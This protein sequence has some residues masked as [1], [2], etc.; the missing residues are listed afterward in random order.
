MEIVPDGSSS[1]YSVLGIC[2]HAS[3]DEIRGAYRKL[4]LKWHPDRCTKDPAIAGEA[5][6]KFQQIQEAYSVLSDKGKRTIYDAGLLEDPP[7]EDDNND[8]EFDKF[9]REMMSLMESERSQ[10]ERSLED[11]QRLLMEMMDRD[12]RLKFELDVKQSHGEA[13]KRRRTSTGG[14]L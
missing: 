3:D 4:A 9:M 6:D 1:H 5:K 11:L 10:E 13:P 2:K 8:K 7:W 12:E 14:G